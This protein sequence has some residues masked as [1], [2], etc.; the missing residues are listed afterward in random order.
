MRSDDYFSPQ[1]TFNPFTHTW[2]LGVEEQFYLVF[3]FLMFAYQRASHSAV[4]K[5]RLI[6]LISLCCLVSLAIC[7]FATPHH[8]RFA[9]Y[10]LPSRFWE[11]GV[12][13][14]LCLTSE[15]W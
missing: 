6:A 1:A 5:T 10:M 13:M 9:F 14:L 8:F 2:S 7:A 11:L 15:R 4:W 12:G 3:P